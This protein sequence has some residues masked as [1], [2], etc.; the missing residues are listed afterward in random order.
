[1]YNDEERLED[2]YDKSY[3]AIKYIS[4]K[5][6][7]IKDIVYVNIADNAK[8]PKERYQDPRKD[9]SGKYAGQYYE[10][11]SSWSEGGWSPAGRTTPVGRYS[12]QKRD[13]SGYVIPNP[14]DKLLR[15]YSSPEGVE[16]LASAVQDVCQ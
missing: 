7:P 13:K 6:L 1:M 3:K 9:N 5:N 11:P 10:D 2:P 14:D 4:K 12:Y 15:F 16:R 8:A